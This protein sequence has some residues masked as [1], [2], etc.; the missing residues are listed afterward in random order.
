ME[1]AIQRTVSLYERLRVATSNEDITDVTRQ[2]LEIFKQ[3]EAVILLLTIIAQHPEPAIRT[4]ASTG[5]KLALASTW[6]FFY[7]Q[8]NEQ[9]VRVN[10]GQV[11]QVKNLILQV[12]PTQQVETAKHVIDFCDAVFSTETKQWPE[13]FDIL[14]KLTDTP[15]H[16]IVGNYLVSEIVQYM[17]GEA[18]VQLAPKLIEFSA[19]AIAIGSPDAAKTGCLSL[20]VVLSFLPPEVIG[21]YRE[22]FLRLME[23]FQNA[24]KSG[25][26][27]LSCEIAKSVGDACQATKLPVEPSDVLTFLCGLL[28]DS[29]VQKELY[30]YVFTALNELVQYHGEELQSVTVQLLTMLVQV[31]VNLDNGELYDDNSDATYVA[32]TAELLAG[33]LKDPNYFKTLKAMSAEAA[34]TPQTKFAYALV[35]FNSWGECKED[36]LEN[37]KFVCEYLF[38]CLK[39]PSPQVRQ[40]ALMLAGELSELFEDDQVDLSTQLVQCLIGGFPG[41]VPDLVV[42]TLNAIVTV[43]NETTLSPSVIQPVLTTLM[44][45]IHSGE[46]QQLHPLAVEGLASLVFAVEEDIAPFAQAVF[47]L[48]L[49][50]ARVPETQAPILKQQAI[51]AIGM[52]LRFAPQQ[53]EP[54]FDNSVALIFNTAST[55]DTDLRNSVMMA[56]GNLVMAKSPALM[57][58]KNEIARLI[59]TYFTSDL[60][61]AEIE[62]KDEDGMIAKPSSLT[63]FTNILRLIK[64]IFKGYVEL[65]PEDCDPWIEIPKAFMMVPFVELQTEAIAA[66][67]Y[68]SVYKNDANVFCENVL[69]LFEN[70]E[71]AVIVGKCF[72]AF[73]VLIE[74]ET[75]FD[76]K[77]LE[78]AVKAGFAAIDGK[79]RCQEEDEFEA[80][81]S[82]HVY[83][84]L[85][86]VFLKFPKVC[87]LT[88]L[89]DHGN[90]LLA[91][92]ERFFEISQYVS[93]LEK[94]FVNS[95]A[96]GSL[97]K[98]KLV[99]KF[100]Q[101]FQKFTQL[102]D[103]EQGASPFCVYPSPISGLMTVLQKDPGNAAVQGIVGNVMQFLVTLLNA[104][105]QGETF[106]YATMTNAVAFMCVVIK[107]SPDTFDYANVLPLLLQKLPLKSDEKFGELIY[108]TIISVVANKG[109]FGQEQAI[110]AAFARTLGLKDRMFNA[111]SLTAETH[112]QLVAMTRQMSQAAGEKAVRDLFEDEQSYQRFVARLG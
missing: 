44:Q 101:A 22:S 73:K 50:A 60:F 76:P 63:G 20:G 21:G 67:L 84:F 9:H 99:E 104:T 51:T 23:I 68:G 5:L 83:N 25:D 1:E 24:L 109:T 45:V 96:M 87:P 19:A 97:S 27:N 53:L 18:L 58:Y 105:Y 93:L 40:I 6:N 26:G 32:T 12:I 92:E 30:V 8:E 4:H 62:D 80:S 47:P 7:C 107:A 57:S 94:C 46:M 66:S 37:M 108:S 38:A 3:P 102:F 13:L 48:V 14:G 11:Q 89:I 81:S 77:F 29:Q 2:L 69:K 59:S 15:E 28:N 98:K 49:D 33:E 71:D 52:L 17:H 86:V 61:S 55:E 43:L 31:I 16:I 56:I 35:F 41:D 70:S 34:K 88:S 36:V 72:R 110:V 39:D 42:P 75:A 78:G 64:W 100:V 85:G 54:V 65:V 112:Q 82:K 10:Q 106:Y 103:E 91:K 90:K 79:L 74:R 95:E 111:M